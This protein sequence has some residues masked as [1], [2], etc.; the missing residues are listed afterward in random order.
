MNEIMDLERLNRYM[1]QT[2][3]QTVEVNHL[4]EAIA[5]NRKVDEPQIE[6]SVQAEQATPPVKQIK[7]QSTSLTKWLVVTAINKVSDLVKYIVWTVVVLAIS[8]VASYLMNA[9][10]N[11]D[12]PA[13]ELLNET[14]HTFSI[15]WTWAIPI[16]EKLRQLL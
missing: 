8:F 16:I 1:I 2:E 14:V 5:S 10:N 11:P 9:K 3:K 15:A 13:G 7:P 6:P 4:I 12:A